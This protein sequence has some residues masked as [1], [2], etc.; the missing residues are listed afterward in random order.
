MFVLY[1]VKEKSFPM[2]IEV[3]MQGVS[4]KLWQRTQ[5]QSWISHKQ[6]EKEYTSLEF[7]IQGNQK[8]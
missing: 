4:M 2:A 3:W 8:C 1:G 5:E 7:N 6:V